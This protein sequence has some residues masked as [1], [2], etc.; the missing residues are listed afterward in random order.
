[1]LL[2]LSRR[3]VEK[4][5][6][7]LAQ[8][9]RLNQKSLLAK[10]QNQPKLTEIYFDEMETFEHTKLKPVSIAMAVTKD[11]K[12]LG[13]FVAPMPAKGLLAKK[14]VDKY[15]KREDKRPQALSGLF[16]SLKKIVEEKAVFKSDQNPHYPL[17]LHRHFPEATHFT[18]KG[19]RGCVVGQGELKAAW[20]DPLFSFNQTAAMLRANMNRLFRRTWCTTKKLEGLKDHLALY[21]DFHNQ[22][23][24]P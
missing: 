4:K 5:F 17:R 3:T 19:L 14:S 20:Y 11:R 2:F 10:L 21:I 15:G 1:M 24:V 23:L 16:R 9:A 8:Q 6:L 7:F 22:I 18:T 12:I 13:A